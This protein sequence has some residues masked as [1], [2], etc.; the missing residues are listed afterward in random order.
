MELTQNIKNQAIKTGF[1]LVGVVS[2][3]PH[4]DISF[5]DKWLGKGYAGSMEYLYR[6]RDRRADPELVLKGAQTIICCGLNYFRG[7]PKSINCAEEGRGWVS[8]YA[9]GEDYHHVVMDKL[10]MLEEYIKIQKPSARLKSYVDT[11]PVLERSYGQSAGVGWIGKNTLLINQKIGSF[12]FLGEILTD[13]P[14]IPDSPS[15]DHCGT[16]TRCLDACPTQALKPYELDANRCISYLTI[17]HHGEISSDL[18]EK[19]GHHFV[20]C[21]ICQDVCPWNRRPPLSN[22]ESFD[23]KAGNF[24]PELAS[25]VALSDDAFNV[26]FKK[27]PIKRMKLKGFRRN[28]DRLISLQ[29]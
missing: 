24:Y 6:G 9:W 27:S 18:K 29:K 14:L 11:G 12:F 16:C 8:N 2:A 4:K 15:H 22:E 20:G 21:D 5:F 10:K 1:D 25:L 7:K 17:E 26:R 28:V 19:M 13:L 23:P 3:K